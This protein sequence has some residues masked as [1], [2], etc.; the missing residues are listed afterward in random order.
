MASRNLSIELGRSRPKVGLSLLRRS[1]YA[2]ISEISR[3][4]DTQTPR[5]LYLC[6][7]TSREKPVWRWL[8]KSPRTAAYRGELTDSFPILPG[9]VRVLTSRDGE[10]GPLPAVSQ[11][12]AERQAVQRRTLREMSDE[13]RRRTEY[14]KDRQGVQLGRDR[15]PLVDLSNGPREDLLTLVSML[16][17]LTPSRQSNKLNLAPKNP[18]NI[19]I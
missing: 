16:I 13:H 7:K 17:L 5:S 4:N 8:C 11:E 18:K 1:F 15:T 14:R 9:G 12:C 3:I 10:H 2:F 6:P 19:R